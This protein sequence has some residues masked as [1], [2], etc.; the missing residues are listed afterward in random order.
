MPNFP[1][2][3]AHVHLWDPDVVRM[4]WIDH[5]EVLN[6]KMLPEK[7][8]RHNGKVDVAGIVYMETGAVP[9]YTLLEAR[10][11]AT[12]LKKS[13]PKIKAVIAAAPIEYGEKSR[14]Y[15]K[16]LTEISPLIKGIRRITQG[17]GDARFCLEPDF[18]R[19]AQL[20]SEFGFSFDLCLNHKQLEATVELVKLCPKTQFIVDHIA[21]PDIKARL[22][23][24]WRAQMTLLAAL[25]NVVCKLS[26]VATEADRD[27]WTVP[28]IEPYV[29]HV[30]KVFGE[31][32]VIFGG[33]WPVL[34]LAGSYERWVAAVDE[35]TQ[36]WT[37]A[38][39]RKLWV[40]NAK[41]FYRI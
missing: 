26:G 32:R 6:K 24:P 29:S 39:Q 34:L 36:N 10:W 25:P 20:V 31:D 11:A 5:N 8:A 4:T 3:D 14:S 13:E 27:H 33:D 1:I 18:V 2:I 17:E 28:D 41:R 12:E 19:G 16:A 30:L 37:P 21:K 40:E 35:L 9:H 7:F 22:L 15:L 23:E 38:A